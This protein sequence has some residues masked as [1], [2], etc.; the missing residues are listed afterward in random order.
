MNWKDLLIDPF[1]LVLFVFMITLAVIG[2]IDVL[3]P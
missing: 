3:K 2:I 1:R